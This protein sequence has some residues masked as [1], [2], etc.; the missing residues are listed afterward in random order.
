MSLTMIIN[1]VIIIAEFPEVLLMTFK[2]LMTPIM[3]SS[4]TPQNYKGQP[5]KERNLIS[6]AKN[7]AR[8][9]KNPPMSYQKAAAGPDKEKWEVSMNTEMASLKD[10]DVWDL[11]EPPI[12]QKI[13]GCKWV[14]KIK[15]GAD[16]SLQKYKARL[17]A[18][19]FTQKY[20]TDFDKTFCPAVRQE[21]LRLLMALS[22]QH[23]LALH[24][25]D[26]TTA[27][28]NG[29]LY[30]KVYMHQPNGY[31]FLKGKRNIHAN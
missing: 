6:M 30:K 4:Q 22:V 17:V 25:M 20:G 26:V 31:M 10:N 24:Q 12:G 11:V 27:F 29:K 13:V 28:F 3:A 15:T 5:E 18:Q 16:G 14:Y 19:G 23:G 2:V 9:Q 21:S 7:T 1:Y 8:F